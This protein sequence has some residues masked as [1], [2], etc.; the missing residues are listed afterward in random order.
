MS[1]EA[2]AVGGEDDD[3]GQ[4]RGVVA[5][6]QTSSHPDTL[7]EVHVQIMYLLFSV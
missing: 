2:G 3:P 5:T 1:G 4:S 6:S 7:P